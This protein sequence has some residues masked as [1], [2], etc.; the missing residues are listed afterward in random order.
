MRFSLLESF[1]IQFGSSAI[2]TWFY[3][4]LETVLI[5][6]VTGPDPISDQSSPE[7]A[8]PISDQ[9]SPEQADPISDLFSL[10]VS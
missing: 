1:V 7:Q 5:V 4:I 2:N 3:G 6:V 10:G 8:D 9:S